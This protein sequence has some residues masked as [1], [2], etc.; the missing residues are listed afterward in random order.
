[1]G[2][3]T[4]YR[5]DNRDCVCFLKLDSGERIRIR[6]FYGPAER[7]GIH[8]DY[9]PVGIMVDTLEWGGLKAGYTVFSFEIRSDDDATRI[10]RLP[11]SKRVDRS[12]PLDLFVDYLADCSSVAE[13]KERC[14]A[15]RLISVD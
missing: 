11:L 1:M 3:V 8:C 15:I 7:F 12:T 6:V 9:I 5:N 10:A 2:K 14:A 4:F 13:V